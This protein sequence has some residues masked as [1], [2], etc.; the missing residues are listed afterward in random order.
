MWVKNDKMRQNLGNFWPYIDF[1]GG[2]EF[3]RA[4]EGPQNGGKMTGMGIPEFIDINGPAPMPK[5]DAIGQIVTWGCRSPPIS[6]LNK[7]RH[8]EA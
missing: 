4:S 2:S 3:S 5:N 8:I 7:S 6:R 1:Q